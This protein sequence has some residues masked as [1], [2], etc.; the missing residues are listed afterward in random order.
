MEIAEKPTVETC[1]TS[2]RSADSSSRT[3]WLSGATAYVVRYAG[4]A[5]S[6][7]S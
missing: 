1:G 7:S 4:S 2:R 6:P 5:S 3:R